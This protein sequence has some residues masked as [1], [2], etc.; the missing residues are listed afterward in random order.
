M[1]DEGQMWVNMPQWES[2]IIYDH[3]YIEDDIIPLKVPKGSLQTTCLK[4]WHSFQNKCTQ[5]L[6]YTNVPW[7]LSEN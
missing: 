2:G 4:Y 5:L 3:D 6:I 7:K 1:Q